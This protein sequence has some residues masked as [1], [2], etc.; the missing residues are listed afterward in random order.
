MNPDMAFCDH[1]NFSMLHASCFYT[2]GVGMHLFR[3]NHARMPFVAHAARPFAV[4]E[5]LHPLTEIVP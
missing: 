5:R 3:H 2:S 1:L 4:A